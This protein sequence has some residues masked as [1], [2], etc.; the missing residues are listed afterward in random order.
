MYMVLR[1]K[2]STFPGRLQLNGRPSQALQPIWLGHGLMNITKPTWHILINFNHHQMCKD[3]IFFYFNKKYK[4]HFFELIHNIIKLIVCR[5][6]HFTVMVADKNNR[7]GCAV[8]RFT[9]AGQSGGQKTSLT[10]CNYSYT[11]LSGLPIYRKGPVASECKTGT[12]PRYPALCSVN[13]PSNY[14]PFE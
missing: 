12:N 14:K 7:V 4:I 5:I 2:I 1:G 11:N 6:G 13:E 10:A 9:Q 3:C 8:A